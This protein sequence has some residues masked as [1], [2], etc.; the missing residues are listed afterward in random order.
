MTISFDPGVYAHLSPEARLYA[1][2]LTPQEPI[3]SFEDLGRVLGCANVTL[4]ERNP[5]LDTK[6][7][8]RAKIEKSPYS[9]QAAGRAALA[10][11]I[12]PLA[13]YL[14]KRKPPRGLETVLRG[15]DHRQLAFMALRS[16][17][18]RIHVGWDEDRHKPKRK[19]KNRDRHCC[20]ELGR[21]VRDELEFAGLLGERWHTRRDERAQAAAEGRKPRKIVTAADRVIA[22]GWPSKT[23]S[24]KEANRLKHIVLGKFRRID[25][26]NAECAQVG[27]WL[28]KCLDDMSCF[29]KDERGF[30]CIHAD[31]KAALDKF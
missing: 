8:T 23:K 15:L 13:A 16:V 24:P 4:L 3:R 25:W 27:D 1:L 28:W 18:D 21:R 20:Q 11:W 14:A 30:L 6:A 22:A 31:H 5:V 29:D 12:E 26:T 7:A 2:G 10:H 17:L 19:I 9:T